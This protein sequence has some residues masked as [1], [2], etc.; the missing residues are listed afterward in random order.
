MCIRDRAHGPHIVLVKA[1]CHTV[2]GGDEDL[3][4]A[5]S[6]PDSDQLVTLSLIHIF[7][8]R[9]SALSRIC[10]RDSSIVCFLSVFKQFFFYFNGR[11]ENL[12]RTAK[13]HAACPCLSVYA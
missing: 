3:L 5:V 8:I 10:S 9:V 2:M 1:D 6:L 7:L 13:V 12:S 11:G 4:A